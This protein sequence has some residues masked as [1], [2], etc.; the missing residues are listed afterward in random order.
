LKN[1]IPITSVKNDVHTPNTV[2]TSLL[3]VLVLTAVEFLKMYWR[4]CE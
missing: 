2:I 3:S 1:K 4:N